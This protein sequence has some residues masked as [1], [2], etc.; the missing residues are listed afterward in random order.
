MA[1]IM[2]ALQILLKTIEKILVKNREKDYAH[3]ILLNIKEMPLKIK[4]W[5]GER[6][7]IFS[8]HLIFNDCLINDH[9][10]VFFHMYHVHAC[11]IISEVEGVVCFGN[12]DGTHTV[13]D[14][15]LILQ[16]VSSAG[17]IRI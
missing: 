10:I 7:G 1:T 11:G 6:E 9:F 2:K 12:D 15:D 8:F 3:G 5:V 14:G 17:I 4:T 16:C 13:R